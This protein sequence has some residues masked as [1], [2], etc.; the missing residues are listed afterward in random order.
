MIL[1]TL[2][3]TAAVS[4]HDRAMSCVRTHLDGG[5]TQSS[6]TIWYDHFERSVGTHGATLECKEGAA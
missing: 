3:T 2:S 4:T 5:G 6:L 1:E